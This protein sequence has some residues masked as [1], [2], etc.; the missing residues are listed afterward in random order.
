[1]DLADRLIHHPARHLREPVVKTGEK[2][3][4][5]AQRQYIVKMGDHVIG[6]LHV[7][8]DPAICEHDASDAADDEH[9]YEA[10]CTEHGCI[11]A[12]R[13]A[14]QDRKSTR[15]NSSH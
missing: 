13:A 15:L 11:E 9:E 12:K 6:V 5:R 10:E 2:R 14:P 4:Y 1:M 8:I 7:V 3:D